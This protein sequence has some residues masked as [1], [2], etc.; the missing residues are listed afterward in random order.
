MSS[1]GVPPA[2]A[3]WQHHEARRGFEVV[4]LDSTPDGYRIEGSTSAAEDEVAWTVAY[5]IEVDPTWTT[6]RAEVRSHS[7]LGSRATVIQADG[8][9]R[10]LVDGVRDPSL[11]GCLDVDLESSVVTNAL[12]VRRLG[13]QRGAQAGAP[14]VYVYANDLAVERLDQ[15]YERS[16]DDHGHQRYYYASPAHNFRCTLVYDDAGLVID[17]PGLAVRVI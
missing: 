5:T 2:V 3:A 11:D 1:F 9:G 15:D 8:P 14:A 17:Y 6:S 10:W 4:F 13:L 7:S 12:P 16:A